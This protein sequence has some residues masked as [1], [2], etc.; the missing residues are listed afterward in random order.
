MINTH[1]LREQVV[2]RAHHVVIVVLRKVR[3]QHIARLARLPVTHIV[4]KDDVVAVDVEGLTRS[5]QNIGELRLQE[6][7]P[8]SSCAMQKQHSIRDV[9][10]RIAHRLAERQVMHAQ[11]GQSLA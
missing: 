4:G 8:R 10:I 11:L 2:L 6:L 1:P 9:S 3:V 7:P 5:V